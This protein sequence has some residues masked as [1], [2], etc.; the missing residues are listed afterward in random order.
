M[1]TRADQINNLKLTMPQAN[2]QVARSAENQRLLELQNNIQQLSPNVGSTSATASAGAQSAQ[3]AGAISQNLTKSNIDTMGQVNQLANVNK[4]SQNQNTAFRDSIQLSKEQLKYN[5][6]LNNL[7]QDVKN[8][9]LDKNLTFQKNKAGQTLLNTRQLLD[10]AVSKSKSAND[11]ANYAQQVQQMEQRYEQMLNAASQKIQQTLEQNY[12]SGKQ[13]LSI[14]QQKRLEQAK[15]DADKKLQQ[16][17]TKSRNTALQIQAAGSLL[18]AG[19]GAAAGFIASGGNP[20]AASAGASLGG[21]AGG[22][23]GS[24]A[25]TT[26]K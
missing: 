22:A 20:L 2:Q 8:Q 24:M 3:K 25:S 23:L 1:P 9:L 16:Q 19:I 4:S 11:F 6:N 15:F 5:D 18:G 7:G 14:E 26:I 21:Q 17:Q 10:Y 13:S 12:M